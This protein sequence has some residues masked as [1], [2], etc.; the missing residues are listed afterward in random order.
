S[1]QEAR[2]VV[3]SGEHI[4]DRDTAVANLVLAA[5]KSDCKMDN[6]E[7]YKPPTGSSK[8]WSSPAGHP[9]RRTETPRRKCRRGNQ[10]LPELDFH[11]FV[12]A[13]NE[14]VGG[15]KKSGVHLYALRK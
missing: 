3:E 6:Y 13:R 7:N 11:I 4:G 2:R 5:A 1:C 12:H 15:R 9:R 14:R 8:N 10:C